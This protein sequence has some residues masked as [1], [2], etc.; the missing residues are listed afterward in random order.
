M[1]ED[2]KERFPE[3]WRVLKQN[4]EEETEPVPEVETELMKVVPESVE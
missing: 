2:L 1:Y 4:G 3:N